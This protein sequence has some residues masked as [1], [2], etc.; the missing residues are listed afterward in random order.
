MNVTIKTPEVVGV[1]QTFDKITIKHKSN[2]CDYYNTR[3]GLG[4]W[5]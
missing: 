3:G 2:E 1:M 5:G 4:G